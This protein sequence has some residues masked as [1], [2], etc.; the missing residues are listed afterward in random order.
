MTFRF[1]NVYIRDVAT[2][3][4]PYESK[5]PLSKEFDQSY[6]DM[7]FDCDSFEKAEVKILFDSI[8]I[9]LNKVKKDKS[10]IDLFISGDLQNQITAS[11]Y[12]ARNLKLPFLGIYSACATNV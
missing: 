8:N 10:D 9:L 4:G 11:S 7:Y 6:D 2:V 3:V 1:D 12:V 5:G